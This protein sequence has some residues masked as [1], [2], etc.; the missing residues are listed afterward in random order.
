[1][2]EPSPREHSFL[3]HVFDAYQN[4]MQIAACLRAAARLRGRPTSRVLE[5]SRRATGLADYVPEAEVTR[6]ATHEGHEPALP[7]P[8]RLPVEDGAFDACVIT[9]V[10]EHLPAAQRPALLAEMVRVTQGV[11]L[12]AAPQGNAVVDRMDRLVFDFIWGKYA[13]AFEP[14]GQHAEFGLEP[15]DEVLSSLAALGAQ[16]VKALPCNYVYRWI[17]QILIYFDLQHEHPHWDLFEPFNRAYN[18]RLAPFDYRE[19]CYRYLVVVSTDPALDLDA[20]AAAVEAPAETPASVAEADGVLVETFRAV[21]ARVSD[22]LRAC[23]RDLRAA[24]EENEAL[25]REVARLG[26]IIRQL[27]EGNQ[28]ALR[29]IEMLRAPVDGSAE[30]A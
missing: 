11:I 13:Q 4:M 24:H 29:E 25:R 10:Y 9:D 12:A 28:W 6:L 1:M 20:L 26:E 18:E 2:A 15:L 7:D 17:H 8:M 19:P 22:R 30:N 27:Q 21:D 5:L 3:G 16:R 14:L 23:A